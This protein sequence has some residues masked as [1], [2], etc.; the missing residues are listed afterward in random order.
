MLGHSVV[1]GAWAFDFS[2]GLSLEAVHCPRCSTVILKGM[3]EACQLHG[4]FLSTTARLRTYGTVLN[5]SILGRQV[6]QGVFLDICA[7][8]DEKIC[9]C[10]IAREEIFRPSSLFGAEMEVRLI[11]RSLLEDYLHF[12]TLQIV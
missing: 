2:W 7:L 4:S 12:F 8:Q 1:A 3:L 6:S 10:I 5:E 11:L 9:P